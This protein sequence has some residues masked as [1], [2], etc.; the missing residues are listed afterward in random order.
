SKSYPEADELRE[1]RL[2]RLFVP[3]S[4]GRRQDV[5]VA[6]AGPTERDGS[7]SGKQQR[8]GFC[9]AG[10]LRTAFELDRE[11]R[12]ELF[13]RRNR[14]EFDELRG[15]PHP[16]VDRDRGGEANLVQTVVQP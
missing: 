1:R 3:G 4:G 2:F 14:A 6:C 7:R 5:E 12:G 9:Y 8:Q 13:S 16:C 11:A 15:R 10:R